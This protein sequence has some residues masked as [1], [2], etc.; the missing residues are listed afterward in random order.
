[1]KEIEM[2]E[3]GEQYVARLIEY[4]RDELPLASI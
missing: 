4:V 3:S 2:T 1:M